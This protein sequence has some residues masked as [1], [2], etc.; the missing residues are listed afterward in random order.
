MYD[1]LV[2]SVKT[3]IIMYLVR[4]NLLERIVLNQHFYQLEYIKEK[5]GMLPFFF[6]F[7]GGGGSHSEI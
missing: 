5:P 1:K 4:I 2:R 3:F 6:F 7:G